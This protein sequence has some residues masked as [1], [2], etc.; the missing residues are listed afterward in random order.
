MHQVDADLSR[1]IRKLWLLTEGFFSFSFFCCCFGSS[2]VQTQELALTRQVLYHLNHDSSP[3]CFSYSLNGVLIFF[4]DKPEPWSS[5]LCLS[6][7]WDDRRTWATTCSLLVEMESQQL[8]A[9]ACL[10][11]QSS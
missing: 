7:S 6:C 5:Y 1:L 3:I 10:E 11:P 9:Q 8:F 4:P 2:D